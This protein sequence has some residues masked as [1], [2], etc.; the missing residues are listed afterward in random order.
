MSVA[1]EAA[2]AGSGPTIARS[3]WALGLALAALGPT[4]RLVQLL[5]GGREE[6][7]KLSVVVAVS[8]LSAVILMLITFLVCRLR[9]CVPTSVGAAAGAVGYL[10]YAA[11]GFGDR[12]ILRVLLFV[13]VAAFAVLVVSALLQH[14]A[15][16][17]A[18]V[19]AGMLYVCIIAIGQ[20]SLRSEP[21][22]ASPTAA[23]TSAAG[24]RPNVYYFVLGAYARADVAEHLDPTYDA[25]PQNRALRS[26]GFS[27]DPIATANYQQHAQSVASTLD[28]RLIITDKT[29]VDDV[30]DDLRPTI[31]G[32]NRT[33]DWFRSNGYQFVQ[34]SV[35]P[36][37]ESCDPNR[38]DE[39]LGVAAS[40]RVVVGET[41]LGPLF[42]R[43]PT[44]QPLLPT[45]VVD[46]LA[47]S[48]RLGG[49]SQ[50]MF[51]MAD[52]VAPHPPYVR[53][54]NCSEIGAVGSLAEGWTQEDKS[55]YADQLRCVAADLQRAVRRLVAM[56][57]SAIIVVQSDTGPAFEV[58]LGA[59]ASALTEQ[60]LVNRFGAFWAWRLPARCRT[61]DKRASSLVNTFAVVQACIARRRPALLD[62]HAYLNWFASTRVE[63]LRSGILSSR[64]R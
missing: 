54:A 6:I 8:A 59:L 47:R 19:L 57:P 64:S 17:G 21:S 51:V 9:D 20:L 63:R 46:A 29:P 32:D 36:L 58:E 22:I 50:P 62:A 16:A 42:H 24:S 37:D 13:M 28:Q 43:K 56:D 1:P 49:S 45:N 41:P 39:C 30:R 33:V 15:V 26:L 3:T 38:A 12:T 23:R 5:D 35:P 44:A 11:G 40:G 34:T 53:A 27:I 18:V 14:R 10:F 4:V 2:S 60:M 25:R 52:I 55:Y 31:Q 48:G 61:T 7:A